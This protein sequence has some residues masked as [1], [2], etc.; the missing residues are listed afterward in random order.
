MPLEYRKFA[1]EGFGVTPKPALLFLS[2]R[3]RRYRCCTESVLGADSRCSG[4]NDEQ[5]L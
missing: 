2:N 4:R 1:S 5:G 3:N